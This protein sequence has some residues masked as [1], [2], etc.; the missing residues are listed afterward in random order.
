MQGINLN[1]PQEVLNL[2]SARKEAVELYKD[3]AEQTKEPDIKKQLL[4]FANEEKGHKA[5]LLSEI[6]RLQGALQWFDP[7]ELTS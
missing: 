5:I 2:P 1:D 3:L 4:Q 7:S 6:Q